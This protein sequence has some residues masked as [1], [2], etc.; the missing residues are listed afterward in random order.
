[1]KGAFNE[2]EQRQFRGHAAGFDFF[3]D[4]VEV[5]A[6]A[7]GHPAEIIRVSCILF[8][9]VSPADRFKG[10][11]RKSSADPIPDVGRSIVARGI[12]AFGGRL[13]VRRPDF[14]FRGFRRGK[15]LFDDGGGKGLRRRHGRHVRVKIGAFKRAHVLS[16]DSEGR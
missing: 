12:A 2:R 8:Q 15:D 13:I 3:H 4:V 7:V 9:C 14:A 16:R 5:F 6:G 10:R 1:M 11:Q